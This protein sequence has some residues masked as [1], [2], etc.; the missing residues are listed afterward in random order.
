MAQDPWISGLRL[1]RLLSQ[2][3]GIRYA[4]CRSYVLL[5]CPPIQHISEQIPDQVL[6]G[7]AQRLDRQAYESPALP[8]S[9]SAVV[10]KLI[11]RG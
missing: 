2:L 7:E 3:R 4:V 5:S 9:Y 6:L 1:W 10:F 11:E 8:L